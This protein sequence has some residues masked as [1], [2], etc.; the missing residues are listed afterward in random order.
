MAQKA[1]WFVFLTKNCVSLYKEMQDY[2]EQAD[3]EKYGFTKTVEV[4]T[5]TD[6]NGKTT[7]KKTIYYKVTGDCS[8]VM[9]WEGVLEKRMPEELQASKLSSTSV[10]EVKSRI[11]GR[12]TKSCMIILEIH[13]NRC[14]K[15]M[16]GN[17]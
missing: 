10:K 7:T 8:R 14:L 2:L 12:K 16:S 3:L 5:E 17:G 15:K 6:E 13:P 9:F 4:S 1:M 11:A